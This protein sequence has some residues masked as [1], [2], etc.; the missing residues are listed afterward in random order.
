MATVV[1]SFCSASD[2]KPDAE[3]VWL[4]SWDVPLSER[5]VRSGLHL[6]SLDT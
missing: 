4:E 5:L 2:A 1:V 6:E 3:T